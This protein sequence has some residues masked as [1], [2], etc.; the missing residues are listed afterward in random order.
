MPGLNAAL[1]AFGLATPEIL[2][3]IGALALVLIGAIRGERSA[4]FV[5]GA[6]LGLIILVGAVVLLRPA[7][8][9]TFGGSFVADG[10]ARFMKLAAL[11]GSGVALVM[12]IDYFRTE[13]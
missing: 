7:T 4:G 10:F 6:A 5:T 8:G 3:A 12:S 13:K 11:V 1:P 9:V 2:L